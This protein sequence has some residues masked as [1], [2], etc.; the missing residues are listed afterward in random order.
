MRFLYNA[1]AY[2][3]PAF[4]LCYAV[5][6]A[7]FVWSYLH[8]SRSVGMMH[9]LGVSRDNLFMTGVLS[10]LAMLLIPYVVVG[11][12]MC[13]FAL[14]YGAMD[15]GAVLLTIAA[16]LL[17]NVLFFG[18]GTLCAMATGN[19]FAVAVYYGVVNF[20][21]P[22]AD[23]LV[24]SLAQEFI[25]GLTSEVSEISLYL[26]PVAGLY[27]Y[28]RVVNDWGVDHLLSVDLEGFPL[29][30]FYGGVGFLLLMVSAFMYR[31]RRSESAGDI[32]AF[33]V[34]RPV[35]RGGLSVLSALTLGRVVYE[36]FWATLFQK[37]TY[38]NLVPMLVCMAITAIV[39]YYV[40]T[41]LLE[42]T[43]RVFKGS[44]KGVAVVC[45]VTVVIGVTVSQDLFGIENR[46][47]DAEDVQTVEVW[48]SVD[49]TYNDSLQS[50]ELARKITE[51]HRTII[52]DQEYIRAYDDGGR[53]DAMTDDMAWT[54][55]H[56]TYILKNGTQLVRIYSLP[57]SMKRMSAPQTYDGK[58]M[59]ILEDPVAL[60]ASVTIP[61][62]AE[63]VYGDLEG[64]N[65][66]TGE[67]EYWGIAPKD[68]GAVYAALLRDAEEGNFH[69][70]SNIYYMFEKEQNVGPD[71]ERYDRSVMLT[72]S[73]RVDEIRHSGVYMQLEP[74]MV[75]TIQALLDAEVITQEIINGWNA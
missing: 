8:N 55:I 53:W 38:A 29:I 14:C 46:V 23:L 18:I 63:L 13:V 30:M 64:Y 22:L 31:A 54:S 17:E 58:I 5:L 24:N 37:G 26:S 39:G 2:F 20:I 1:A 61:E 41:M 32:V 45:A 15:V 3:L 35:L 71:W 27:N 33:R 44:L 25:F 48:G 10:G 52:A 51:L 40:A 34:L 66:E 59:A 60:A 42:K 70:D 65:S 36:L 74:G 56:F 16:V 75:H 67:Y 9:S 47:P 73:Y 11:A 68:C 19:I 6:V 72:L 28:V 49:V 50:V 43:L 4:T 7:M 21:V 62:D 69:M 12:L 57:V